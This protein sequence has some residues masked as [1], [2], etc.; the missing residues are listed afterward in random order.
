MSWRKV[1]RVKDSL[2][3]L[4]THNTHNTHNTSKS[5]V[6][7]NSAYCAYCAYRDEIV[8]CRAEL[9]HRE[10]YLKR[11]EEVLK[12]A[13]NQST[14][15]FVP[16]AENFEIPSGEGKLIGLGKQHLQA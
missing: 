3:N 4:Y 15:L 2:N 9:K 7:G 11:S 10:Y 8:K 1:P 16:R 13:K 6:P 12:L 14:D 5:S